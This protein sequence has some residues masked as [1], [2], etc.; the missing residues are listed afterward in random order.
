MYRLQTR[1]DFLFMVLLSTAVLAMGVAMLAMP[2]RSVPT[3]AAAYREVTGRLATVVEGGGRRVPRVVFTIV[4]DDRRF[5]SNAIGFRDGA[6][7]WMPGRTRLDFF[8]E[9]G[10]P[11]SGD[12][13]RPIAA[14]GLGVDG[15]ALRSLAADISARNALA[16]SWAGLFASALGAVGLLVAAL[17]WRRHPPV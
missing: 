12:A 14:F 9:R 17:A 1:S 11:A 7:R 5:E 10:D 6:E 2:A 8:V 13:G 3:D 16:E 4:G 15:I